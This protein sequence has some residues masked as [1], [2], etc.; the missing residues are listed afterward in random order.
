MLRCA[1]D[2]R[3]VGGPLL[4]LASS[5]AVRILGRGEGSAAR[6]TK[7]APALAQ[8]LRPLR[9]QR[10]VLCG[11]ALRLGAKRQY[12]RLPCGTALVLCTVGTMRFYAVR[13]GRNQGVFDS[14]TEFDAS[15]LGFPRAEGKG[16][17][18]R[19]EAEKYLGL[20]C[21]EEPAAA[22][23]SDGV[24]PPVSTQSKKGR[25]KRVES[26]H[27]KARKQ[28]TIAPKSKRIKKDHMSASFA[29]GM[30]EEAARGGN[31]ELCELLLKRGASK[32]L[33]YIREHFKPVS[34][35]EKQMEVLC[36]LI[37]SRD[38][39][40]TLALRG[41]TAQVLQA[42]DE[43]PAFARMMWSG[44]G[45]TVA[46]DQGNEFKVVANETTLL[47][48]ASCN[49]HLDL[50]AGL[51]DRGAGLDE[52]LDK[53]GLP[54]DF[55]WLLDNEKKK[56]VNLLLT[57][58]LVAVNN[59]MDDDN[60][61]LGLMTDC[62]D[63]EM[64][65]ILMRHG[66][67]P[68]R[69][70]AITEKVPFQEAAANGSMDILRL[71]VGACDGSV[72]DSTANHTSA[73]HCAAFAGEID[74]CRLLVLHGGDIYKAWPLHDKY[75]TTPLDE[76]GS[77]SRMNWQQ[78]QEG[79]D[80]LIALSESVVQ[81]LRM[82]RANNR[83]QT[84]VLLQKL[85][86]ESEFL[87]MANQ[88]FHEAV[89]ARNKP[90]ITALLDKKFVTD[91]NARV[92]GQSALHR[93]IGQHELLSFL[94]EKGLACGDADLKLAIAMGSRK[95]CLLLIAKGA[96]LL[97]SYIVDGRASCT[98]EKLWKKQWRKGKSSRE[99][100]NDG[101][102]RNGLEDLQW[103]YDAYNNG[104]H[105]DARW[106]RRKGFL[107]ALV[108]SKLLP[109]A[110]MQAELDAEQAALDKSA[111]APSEVRDKEWII[112]HVFSNVGLRCNIVSYL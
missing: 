41:Q 1:S 112:R 8:T 102:K 6:G 40:F 13:N 80:A 65:E 49:Q 78:K 53:N 10:A 12:C 24:P 36:S 42:V 97:K 68:F 32:S 90:L 59:H 15:V 106:H 104:P 63:F 43:N 75:A 47:S 50:M 93:A 81:C 2:S 34:D 54:V 3:C 44:E 31:F 51:A 73:L 52:R 98:P 108:G 89:D 100:S 9:E 105:P 19:A 99:K 33:Q 11:A 66:A 95:C 87:E 48:L 69:W 30:F 85:Q 74:A 70:C 62:A 29:S 58:G 38:G 109:T 92:K 16:F 96:K 35:Q 17:A 71:F 7:P 27:E 67:S 94:L 101:G 60:E 61:A 25:V 76:F 77:D 21:K 83:E 91:V 110:A 45:Y 55:G 72:D 84:E 56:S 88:L 107:C 23:R 37:V 26:D 18:T 39:L 82:A 86:E 14:L 22:T 28:L 4:L 46:D 20:P 79:Y 64:C 57:K 111:P 5:R 103:L